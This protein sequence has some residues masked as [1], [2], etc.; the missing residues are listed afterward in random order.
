MILIYNFSGYSIAERIVKKSFKNSFGNIKIKTIKDNIVPSK[1]EKV[2]LV[3]LIGTRKTIT[4]KLIKHLNVNKI[5]V[6]IF[7]PLSSD[8]SNI[9]NF[10]SNIK[11]NDFWT[12]KIKKKNITFSDLYIQYQKNELQSK[13]FKRYFE[14]Y[15]YNDEWNNYGY[16][17]IDFDNKILSI[18]SSIRISNANE[19]SYITDSINNYYG[20]YCGL[21]KSDHCLLWF[22]R[23]SGPFDSFEWRIVENFV[24]NLVY[25]NFK[26]IPSISEI[27]FGARGIATSRLDCD[28]DIASSKKLFQFYKKKNIPL[29]LAIVTDLLKDKKNRLF[30]SKIKDLNKIL[31]SHSKT[32]RPNWGGNFI[33]AKW[34]AEEAKNDIYRYFKIVCDFAVAPFHHAP[35]YAI[36][37]LEVNKYK[38]L[39]AG[40]INNDPYILIARSGKSIYSEKIISLSQ[41]CMIHGD[42]LK[43]NED[44]KRYYEIIDQ[45]K[46]SRTIFGYL[47]H[48]LSKRYSYGW[49][50]EETRIH[51]HKKIINYL[52][53]KKFTF[54]SI[55]EVFRFIKNKNKI[56]IHILNKGFLITKNSKENLLYA[57]EYKGKFFKLDTKLEI[58]E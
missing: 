38:G 6:I 30:L 51:F 35:P 57:I 45:Y 50:N 41:Q 11:N 27:P 23:L 36:K 22:N 55:I 39:V 9:L 14:R 26:C 33:A 7:G 42:I 47:D 4:K 16:G 18:S 37:A 12:V 3:I 25:K 21:W 54:L 5:K 29:S 20:S 44:L 32:H 56:K 43:T 15:D 34:E 52:K 8:L 53:K 10:Q 49:K 48:P 19:I 31:L 58:Y 1:L 13:N 24:S 40:I 2:L 17:K 46:N 28:E